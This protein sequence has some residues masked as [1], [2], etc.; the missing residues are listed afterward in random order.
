MNPV[1]IYRF[2]RIFLVAGMAVLGAF[3]LFYSAAVTYPFLIG[4]ALA[5]LIN[6]AVKFL[7]H[8]IRLP[9][10]LAVLVTL[11][12]IV[13]LFAG[14]ITLLI[15]EIITGANYLGDNVPKQ[16]AILVAYSESLFETKI[17][18]IYNSIASLFNN[19]D[20]GQQQTIL[21]NIQE[22]G[23]AITSSIGSFIKN[24]FHK[25]PVIVGW[26]PSAAT[27]LVF[28]VLATFFISNDWYRLQGYA[29]KW[30]PDIVSRQA[31]PII[32]DLKRALF[33]YITAQLTLISMTTLIVLIGL[34]ILRVEYAITIALVTGLV[35]LLPYL[36]SGTVFI[37]WII[38]QAIT[39]NV[40][41]AIG[42]G[43]LYTVVLVQRQ[44]M[45][46]KVLS[47]SIGLDPLATL[48]ALFVGFKLLGFLGLIIGPVTLV[49]IQTLNKSNVFHELW[50]YIK[51]AEE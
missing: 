41:L 25:I 35:D 3:A 27:G 6:P 45:E 30:I 46:P 10:P 18:P 9:R 34:L 19:L 28:S 8:S 47:S 1:H 21:E 43:I 33:G 14:L 48:V 5:V 32:N 37:P 51:G 2:V 13:L 11:L 24:F 29:R 26:I 22:A 38:Y 49:V 16:L 17:L 20:T 50:A 31:E 15:A 44:V 4:F 12:G 40:G 39:G 42:L 36:G 7:Q 23:S